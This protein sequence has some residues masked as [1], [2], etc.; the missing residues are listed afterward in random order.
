MPK[1]K[2]MFKLK[3]L[4]TGKHTA[5]R[6]QQ[7]IDRVKTPNIGKTKA[8]SSMV[9]LEGLNINLDDKKGDE[10]ESQKFVD[11]TKVEGIA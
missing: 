7:E 11:N 8:T 2:P 1:Q 9:F 10:A 3:P 4:D 5:A 6:L